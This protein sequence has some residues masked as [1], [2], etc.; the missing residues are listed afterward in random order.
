MKATFDGDASRVVLVGRWVPLIREGKL[1]WFLILEVAKRELA[2]FYVFKW[3][4]KTTKTPSTNSTSCQ[5]CFCI[6]FYFKYKKLSITIIVFSQNITKE[7]SFILVVFVL[8]KYKFLYCVIICK[9]N[10]IKKKDKFNLYSLI[11][12]KEKWQFKPI[13]IIRL[14][15]WRKNEGSIIN[16]RDSRSCGGNLKS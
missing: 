9:R 12:Y 5:Q 11:W 7:S 4:N 8:L 3:G 16:K 14:V 13:K 2:M 15:T 1:V 6:N 10:Y